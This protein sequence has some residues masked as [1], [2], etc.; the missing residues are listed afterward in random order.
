MDIMNF[1]IWEDTLQFED[2][3]RRYKLPDGLTPE[4]Q[5]IWLDREVAR[6]A[7]N[8]SNVWGITE[9]LT[10]AQVWACTQLELQEQDLC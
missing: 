2:F 9:K 10:P 7:A 5:V 6:D 8:L 4:E 1:L 3:V